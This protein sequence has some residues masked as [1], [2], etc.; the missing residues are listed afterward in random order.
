MDIAIIGI[1]RIGLV[2]AC[3]LAESG[4]R[5][6]GI[7]TDPAKL[8]SLNGGSH[9]YEK[10]LQSLLERN[11]AS[12][13]L[14]LVPELPRPLQA[15]VVMITVNTPCP[16]GEFD[17]TNVHAAIKQICEAARSPLVLVMKSTVPPGTGVE[18]IRRYLKGTPVAY[19]ANP[20]FLR[21]GQAVDD[22]Y[23]PSRIVIGSD[24]PQAAA[25]VRR[26]YAGIE[27]PIIE[28]DITSAELIKHAAN[29]FLTLKVSFINE[30]ANLCQLLGADID[31][32]RQ[33]LGLDPRIG[34]A[35]LQ[36]GVG[37]GGPC[38][39]K[40]AR[41]LAS[42]ASHKGY[43]FKLILA[44]LEVNA[45]QPVLIVDRVREALGI[46]KGKDIALLGLAFKPGTDDVTESPALE[47]ARLLIEEGARLRAY[48]PAAMPDARP[49]L[50]EGVTFVSEVYSAVQGACA[51]I[52]ATE[53]P[54]L[55]QADWGKIKKVMAEP[56]LVMDG[57]NALP[58][59]KLV[60]AGF[61][62]VGVGRSLG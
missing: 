57:R 39:P 7:E 26:L 10:G 20:E 14:T 61:R 33:G 17:L 29:A 22:W 45:R 41:A 37:Y 52:L 6:T 9:L 28:T 36:P 13:R 38:L 11:L 43:D 60:A 16:A 4:H 1:G 40:D 59:E 54:E 62:Y 27:A 55:I 25:I 56:Y 21:A 18:L 23:H 24:S 8:N 31:A 35:F 50:T 51:V 49:L 32:V 47:L 58:Q 3:C 5:V 53:W 44:A 19:V 46:L 12:G 2:A 42:L 34:T 15:E 48:D 30:V